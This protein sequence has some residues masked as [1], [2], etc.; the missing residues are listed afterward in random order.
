MKRLRSKI[1]QKYHSLD[2]WSSKSIWML[3]KTF[4]SKRN[5]IAN[6]HAIDFVESISVNDFVCITYWRSRPEWRRDETWS[7]YYTNDAL[8]NDRIRYL[9]MITLIVEDMIIQ[10]HY[11]FTSSRD[12]D[13]E[14]KE[15]FGS[16]IV[17]NDNSGL[18]GSDLK[19]DRFEA[20]GDE[21]EGYVV[22]DDKSLTQNKS[23][24]RISG[25]RSELIWSSKSLVLL[26]LIDSLKFLNLIY[27]T[28]SRTTRS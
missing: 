9:Q 25:F 10:L 2:E 20:L 28:D 3:Q 5:A 27:M 21:D 4:I 14:I 6:E 18:T 19:S 8:N 26:S 13:F 1:S 17:V 12:A 15:L 7:T 24:H 23:H 22:M 11:S 16:K